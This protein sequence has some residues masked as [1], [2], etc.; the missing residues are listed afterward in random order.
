MY[1]SYLYISAIYIFLVQFQL[2]SNETVF[3]HFQGESGDTGPKGLAG[4][5][6]ERVSLM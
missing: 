1:Y 4:S 3:K 2:Y 6:G 5:N